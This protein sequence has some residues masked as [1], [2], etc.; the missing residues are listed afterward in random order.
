MPKIVDARE[1]RRA[2]R[3]AAHRVFARRGVD[4]TG[5][6][7][8]A[9]AAGMGRATLYHYYRDKA[10][11]VRDLARDL[12]ME[13]ER[14]FHSALTGHD[15][16]LE[17]IE[18]LAGGLTDLFEQW[19]VLGRV[20]LDLWFRDVTR[21]RPFFRRIR[22]DL[23]ELIAEGQRRGAIHHELDPPI[24]SGLV[25][26]VIDGVLL[27]HFVDPGAFAD[28]TAVRDAVVEAVHRMLRP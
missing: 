17:R 20:L 23:A 8:V 4:G 22:A 13:E 9:R 3:R 5:L 10:S 19:R 7:H 6:V 21:S 15:G 26:G 16:P 1:Q 27:Q 25:I 18:R 14:Y 12:L 2:I 11:L 28:P 24:A